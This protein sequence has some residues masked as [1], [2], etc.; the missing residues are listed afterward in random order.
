VGSTLVLALVFGDKSS[1]K[2]ARIAALNASNTHLQTEL[3]GL[4]MTMV[5]LQTR[6]VQNGTCAFGFPLNVN[7]APQSLGDMSDYVML[8]YTLKEVLLA[9][10]VPLTV[11]EISATPRPIVFPGYTPPAAASH[12][13]LQA[14]L[15]LFDPPIAT[16]DSLAQSDISVIAYSYTI[17]SRIALTPNCVAMSLSDHDSAHCTEENAYTPAFTSSYPSENAF[18][19]YTNNIE[20]AGDA[21]LRLSWGQWD[22]TS[23]GT[24][25]NFAGTGVLFTAPLQLTLPN[26]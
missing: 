5:T 11:L 2:D 3:M 7:S 25:Y 12:N 4:L 13:D 17:A 8:N 21:Q 26:F 24:E 15:G 19:I 1:D 23:L 6:Y 22:Y 18:L 10:S 16:L 14:V 20:V 9:G